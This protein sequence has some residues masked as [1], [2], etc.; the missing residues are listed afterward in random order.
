MA[1][2]TRFDLRAEIDWRDVTINGVTD[3]EELRYQ[4]DRA[5]LAELHAQK[6]KVRTWRS[7]LRGMFRRKDAT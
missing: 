3:P 2:A 1:K 7:K 4:R 6:H 5:K